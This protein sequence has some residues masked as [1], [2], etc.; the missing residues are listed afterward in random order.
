MA[1]PAGTDDALEPLPQAQ[2]APR[3]RISIVWLI[4][5]VALVIGGWLAYKTYSEQGPK[6]EIRF[7]SAAGLQAG[8]TKVK[9]KDVEVG[10]VT[11]IV[12]TDDLKHVLV[13]AQLVADAD[14]YLTE[15][16][17]FWVSRPRV[18]AGRRASGRKASSAR[19][20][21]F[22]IKVRAWPAQTGRPLRWIR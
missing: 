8:K 20:R 17:R 1:E 16:T 11:S 12:V 5:V 4:P 14:K 6:I 10:E 19:P 21:A 3:S 2:L 13:R 15:G 7:N 9:Y 22:R 18:T